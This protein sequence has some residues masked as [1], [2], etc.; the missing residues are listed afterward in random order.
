MAAG[1]L[2]GGGEA[3][4]CEGGSAPGGPEAAPGR[5]E[6]Q[7]GSYGTNGDPTAAPRRPAAAPRRQGGAVFGWCL[8]FV[9]RWL[10][11][12]GLVMILQVRMPGAG[13]L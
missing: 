6:A 5:P 11:P 7:R 9:P 13:A 12:Q 1:G 4:P 2:R 3:A 10:F 8:A